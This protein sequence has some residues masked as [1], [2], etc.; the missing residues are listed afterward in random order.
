VEH[1]C[2]LGDGAPSNGQ[3]DQILAQSAQAAESLN[4]LNISPD[5]VKHS[6]TSGALPNPAPIPAPVFASG[7][8]VQS[9]ASAVDGTTNRTVPSSSPLLTSIP[10]YFV[11]WTLLHARA[12]SGF[13]EL[14]RELL[15]R[16]VN[17]DLRNK[18]P[19]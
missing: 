7:S 12:L 1:Q 8:D 18:T 19:H 6:A 9:E 17:L 10:F 3:F 11:G 4:H 16:K 13:S 15:T 2:W 5:R 14:L